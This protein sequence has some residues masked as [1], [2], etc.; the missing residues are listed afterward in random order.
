MHKLPQREE[1][2]IDDRID[3]AMFLNKGWQEDID[4]RH[5]RTIKRSKEARKLPPETTS[6]V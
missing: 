3:L 6:Q 1:F 5:H 2:T 4:R